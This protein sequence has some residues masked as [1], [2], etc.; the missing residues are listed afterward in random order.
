MAPSVSRFSARLASLPFEAVLEIAARGCEEGAATRRFAD[1]LCAR[2][3]PT[4]ECIDQVL[5]SPEL[6]PLVMA[7]LDGRAA[8]AAAVCSTWRRVWDATR[9]ERRI[10]HEAGPHPGGSDH[11]VG[12]SMLVPIPNSEWLCDFT[13]RKKPPHNE[14]IIMD[15][16]TCE[17]LR[18]LELPELHYWETP[19]VAASEDSIYTALGR[20]HPMSGSQQ[21]TQP[22][23]VCRYSLDNFDRL[24]VF[25]DTDENETPYVAFGY[26]ILANGVLYVLASQ[27]ERHH[28][29]STVLVL[30]PLTLSLQDDLNLDAFA[31]SKACGMAMMGNEIFLAKRTDS[32]TIHV[33]SMDLQQRQGAWMAHL[34]SI[35]PFG[36]NDGFRASKLICYD[37]RL[38]IGAYDP[39]RKVGPAIHVLTKEGETL[40][41]WN[42]QCGRDGYCDFR[43]IIDR[44]L[45]IKRTVGASQTV[46]SSIELQGV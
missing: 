27:V 17:T 30:D 1:E 32:V 13:L 22:A 44:K 23:M 25:D 42:A 18:T 41:V 31:N 21:N 11:H 34:R 35:K 38:Y 40:Q 9:V 19:G 10:L 5:L 7:A 26:P 28:E 14:I 12:L 37:E 16:R 36:Y 45:I 20:G 24:A 15:K 4:A 43:G 33:Y 29:N 3:Q 39:D 6:L 8:A 2:H 46:T